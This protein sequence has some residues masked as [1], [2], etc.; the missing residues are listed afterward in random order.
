ML[1][2]AVLIANVANA[3][4][5]QYQDVHYAVDEITLTAE[6]VANPRAT[7]EL[8][9]P[10]HIVVGQDTYTVVAIGD[11]AFKGCK[12][13]TAIVLPQSIERVYRSAFE[14]TGIMLNK[15]IGD[16]VKKGDLLCTLHT[17][18]GEKEYA[19][20]IED[21]KKAYVIVKEKVE[22]RPV[23]REIIEK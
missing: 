18:K 7:G 9:I 19:P 8:F 4:D 22:A 20:I 12:N 14:G 2:V 13:L 17:N 21:V 1:Q 3:V 11:K 5:A 16:F 23:I 6:V 10:E 15:K